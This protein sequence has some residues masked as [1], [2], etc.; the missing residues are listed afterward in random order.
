MFFYYDNYV[1]EDL[2]VKSPKDI[3]ISE[4]A[5]CCRIEMPVSAENELQM[6][7]NGFFLA[8][9]TMKVTVN[10]ENLDESYQKK[11]RLPVKLTS[12]CNQEI[13]DIACESF[14]T[15]RRFHFLPQPNQRLANIVIKD[16]VKSLQTSFMCSFKDHVVGFIALKNVTEKESEIYLAAVKEK[17][18]LAGAALSL[19]TTA[20]LN[21]KENGLSYVT[22]RI[23]T[24]NLPV[25]NL[26]ASYGAKFSEVNDIFLKEIK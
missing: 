12:D 10:L 16:Y 19:Y 24:S 6:Q 20:L 11:I 4:A 26:Y 15:D 21:A 23:S 25:M 13:Y 7:K 5:N 3:S 8:D 2:K 14:N 9:R 18:R 17:Y 1:L 22:G